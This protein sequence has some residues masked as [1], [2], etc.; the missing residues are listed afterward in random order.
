MLDV[1]LTTLAYS[2]GSSHLKV[3]ANTGMK[4]SFVI[5]FTP[6]YRR[7]RIHL[8]HQL[9]YTTACALTGF[10]LNYGIKLHPFKHLDVI[11]KQLKFIMS[12]VK[13]NIKTHD[14]VLCGQ[15]QPV[16][17]GTRQ[18]RNQENAIFHA[19]A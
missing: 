15:V 19:N 3:A 11:N 6:N 1:Q 16:A 13:V 4:C 5:H 12:L 14:S 8:L 18:T 7:G 17:T 2:R 9:V 10:W